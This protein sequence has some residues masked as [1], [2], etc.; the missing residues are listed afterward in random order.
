MERW[1]VEHRALVVQT[2]LKKQ[3]FCDC[4]SVDILSHFNIHR[5]ECPQL[6]YFSL[7][8]Y[9]KSKVYEKKPWTMVDLKQNIRDDEVA[10]ISPTMLQ[11]VMQKFQKRLRECVNKAI[12][13]TL[14]S[15]SEYCN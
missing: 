9:L 6:Q 5:N 15:G 1:S 14:Y 13:Q 2:Y 12:L 4:D 11:Q 3:R 8:G 10:A 7:W